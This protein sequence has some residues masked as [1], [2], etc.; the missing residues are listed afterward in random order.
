M[1]LR[2]SLYTLASFVVTLVS[3][4]NATAQNPVN[5]VGQINTITTSVPFL[6][7][8]PD[9]R[10][11]GIGDQGVAISPDANGAYW[12]VGKMAMIESDYGG[13]LTFTPWLSELNIQDIF[14][15]HL[16]GYYRIDEQQTV[17]MNFRY[18]SLGSIPYRDDNNNELSEGNPREM[19]IDGYY[20][21][22]FS[23]KFS[24]GIT[25]K[26]IWSGLSK[27]I[28]S[29]NGAVFSPGSAVATDFG[30]YYRSGPK[31]KANLGNEFAAGLAI[32]NLGTKI[33]YSQT[34]K[35][36]IPTNL[37]I[38]ARYSNQID[39][40]NLLSFSL[41]TNKLL[42]PSPQYD[43]TGQPYMPNDKSVLDGVF[44]SFGDAPGGFSEELREFTWSLG[45]EYWYQDQF[46][47]RAGYFYEDKTKGARQYAT[48]GLG[49]KFNVFG[50][51]FSYIMPTNSSFG[52]RMPLSNT[53]RFSL[54]FDMMKNTAKQP[55]L[56]TKPATD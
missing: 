29:T 50:L 39:E 24:S 9:A 3:I 15:A 27:G 48:L 19:E 49:V 51:N 26:Y 41:E 56:P 1:S 30:F 18:F 45:A 34:E 2:K 35:F 10:S 55:T 21:R 31:D 13:G 23:D 53:L 36:F 37:G 17:G 46:A 6:R 7:I 22:K 52:G 25:F 16:D 14:L 38:G 54:I 20:S 11:G 32:N 12:N 43:S 47:V 40:Y 33:T 42:V 8:S 5:T 44:S 4:K 28:V